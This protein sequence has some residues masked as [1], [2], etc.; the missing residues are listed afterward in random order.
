MGFLQQFEIFNPTTG[1][2]PEHPFSILPSIAFRARALLKSRTKEQ[3]IDAAYGID[4]AIDEYFS[5]IKQEKIIELKHNLFGSELE[6]YFDWSGDA[7]ADG[8]WHFKDGKE[9]ELDIATSEN[10][11]EVDA[12]KNCIDWWDDIGGEDFPN[13][14]TYELFAVLALWLLVDSMRWVKSSELKFDENYL[15]FEREFKKEL[16]QKQQDLYGH[17]ISVNSNVTN[18][19]LS[20]QSALTAMDAVCYAE[21]LFLLE[22][23]VVKVKEAQKTQNQVDEKTRRS[24]LSEKLNIHRHQKRNQ[25]VELVTCEWAKNPSQFN[26]AEKAGVHFAHWLK[27]HD[28]QFEPRTITGWLRKYAKKVGIRLR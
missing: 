18:L 23:E 9:E 25:A 20:G 26:S 22:K 7:D 16:E 27:E 4:W 10:T 15:R 6:E 24:M 11:N 17:I 19:S 2:V 8:M 3:I 21:H 5:E 28:F 13:G 1:V 14:K 12:L